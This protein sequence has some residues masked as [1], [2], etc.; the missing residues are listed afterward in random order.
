MS[1]NFVPVLLFASMSLAILPAHAAVQDSMP[2]PIG[3]MIARLTPLS[4]A[5]SALSAAV[6]QHPRVLEAISEQRGARQNTAEVRSGLLP[7]IDAGLSLDQS[8]ARD[9]GTGDSNRLE[10]FRPRQRIDAT[11]TGQQLITDFGATRHRIDAAKAY[12]VAAQ[13]SARLIAT[14]IAVNA[15]SAWD[16]LVL[17]QTQIKL[18][19]A[20]LARHEQI[21]RDTQTRFDQG[22]G[23]KSDV[24][25]VTAYVA[26]AQ[27]Q[28]ARLRRDL[29]SAKARYRE[30]FNAPALEQLDR[31]PDR[32]SQ[33]STMD[34]ALQL[35][36]T[37][38]PA[39]ARAKSLTNRA[40][41]DYAAAR[42]DRLPKLSVQIDASRF[43]AFD[44]D[45]D[46]DVRGR[47]VSRYPLFSGGARGARAAQA[48]QRFQGAQAAQ[49]RASA[50]LDRDVTIAF[51][52]VT[53]LEAQT[54][55]FRQAYQ[56]NADA[57]GF[58]IEQFKV[59]RG[60]LLDLLQAEQ[61]T[62]E[63]GLAYARSITELTF[64]RHALLARTGE[65]LPS[66]GVTLSFAEAE[67]L[68]GLK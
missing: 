33:A 37:S 26:T 15:A 7:T 12:D 48:L 49:A 54:Q 11:V 21:L 13:A 19:D 63:A 35:A 29:A 39:S 47:I 6:N 60:S 46:Y 50:E 17:A 59:A 23:P 31:L 43:N 65:L 27:G 10:Q 16:Q 4:D 44:P 18:G 34:E 1:Q 57:R 66:I 61:D 62:F 58:F 9:F 24:A 40:D 30:V 2:D 67:S 22:V 38:N 56:A 64:A 53:A 20:F 41:A 3:Q 25:R 55:T 45:A 42:A 32:R 28:L 8:L 36:A 52:E 68:W 51:E 5:N 14:E